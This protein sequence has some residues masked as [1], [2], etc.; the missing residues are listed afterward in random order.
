M[1]T[2][3]F[4]PSATKKADERRRGT[5]DVES[6]TASGRTQALVTRHAHWH[7]APSDGASAGRAARGPQVH[8]RALQDS[9][10]HRVACAPGLLGDRVAEDRA[11]SGALQPH[12][13]EGGTAA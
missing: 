5:T 9:R 8:V 12:V 1:C 3:R 13:H 11:V 4:P 2:L 6:V 7:A 10:A